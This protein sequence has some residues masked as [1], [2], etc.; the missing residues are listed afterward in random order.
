FEI[1]F[2]VIDYH[3]FMIVGYNSSEDSIHNPVPRKL[4]LASLH[5]GILRVTCY[6]T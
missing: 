1:L 5:S 4:F 3:S 6:T 2:K